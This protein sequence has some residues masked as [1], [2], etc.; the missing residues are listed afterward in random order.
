MSATHTAPATPSHPINIGSVKVWYEH[1]ESIVSNSALRKVINQMIDEKIRTEFDNDSY[2]D[3]LI[4]NE[5]ML[6]RSSKTVRMLSGG[7]TYF[8]ETLQ[9]AFTKAFERLHAANGKI[10][11]LVVGTEIPAFLAAAQKKY[12]G[13]LQVS[14]AQ[15]RNEDQVE[16]FIVCDSIMARV[17]KPHVRLQQNTPI[18]AIKAKVS[19]NNASTAKFY[20]DRFDAVWKVLHETTATPDNTAQA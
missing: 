16:H 15:A 9:D 13:T 14:S 3:A 8:L 19:F 12:A 1:H 20:E 2:M 7:C 5:I 10:R 18:D 17:E 11:I 6:D 4:L